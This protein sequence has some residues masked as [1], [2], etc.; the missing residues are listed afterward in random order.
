V[1]ALLDTSVLTSARLPP[2][3]L[4]DQWAVSVVTIGE[5][6]TGVVLAEDPAVRAARLRRLTSILDVAVIVPV[7]RA[8]SSRYALLRAATGRRPTNDLW[9]AATALAHDLLL[10]TRDRKQAALPH[11]RAS[12]VS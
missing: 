1:T 6:E 9:I 7:D 10:V 12:L 4:R 2:E 11:V 5:L 3:F 8:V